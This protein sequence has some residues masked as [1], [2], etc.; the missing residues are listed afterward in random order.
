MNDVLL[1]VQSVGRVLDAYSA[2]HPERGV[3]E[4]AGLLGVSKSKAHALLA[5]MVE[6]GLLRRVDGG[7]YRL[8][9]RAL[10]LVRL[11]T[12]TTPFRPPAHAAATALARRYGEIVHVAT[13]DGGRVVYV[14][15]I[16]GA[17]GV[18]LPV[19]AIGSSLPA[20]CSGVGKALLAHLPAAEIDR[21]LDDHGLP[22]LTPGTITDRDALAAEL[23]RIRRDGLSYDREEVVAGLSCV[24]APIFDPVGRAVAA[25]SVSA[26]TARLAAIEPGCGVA[27]RRASRAITEHL[28]FLETRTL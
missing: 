7:R 21:V 26:P 8:G 15:R 11:I 14:D 2:E 3:T 20:H 18:D 12:E 4:I 23:H 22:R 5:S 6:I 9:W 16:V 1:T 24:A 17:D 28:R 25:I 19:S 13:L 10:E 27:V